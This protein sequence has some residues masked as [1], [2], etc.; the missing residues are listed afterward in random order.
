VPPVAKALQ[1][2]ADEGRPV[3]GALPGRRGIIGSPKVVRAGI[4]SV[5]SEY[6]ADE[7]IIVTICH[8]HAARRRSYEL[9]AEAMGLSPHSESPAGV[10]QA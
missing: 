7:V 5:A 9:I 6:G 3:T 4:E 1:F 10:V 8:D 2:L